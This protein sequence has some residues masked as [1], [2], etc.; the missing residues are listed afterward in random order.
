M[1]F[2]LMELKLQRIK[3]S[4][5]QKDMANLLG[6]SASTYNKKET[7]DIK[8]SVEEFAKI[9]NIFGMHDM[10]IFFKPNVDKKQQKQKE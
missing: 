3:R 10:S 8:I 5:T 4:Y 7:G 9:A 6:I 2:D 1:E